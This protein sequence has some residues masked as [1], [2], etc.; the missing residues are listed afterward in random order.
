MLDDM[1][2]P[3]VIILIITVIVFAIF[4]YSILKLLSVAWS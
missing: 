1:D 4:I 3:F 2:R